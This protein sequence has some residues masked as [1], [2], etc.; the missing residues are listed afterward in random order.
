MRFVNNLIDVDLPH[1]TR[2]LRVV[3][4]WRLRRCDSFGDW[5]CEYLPV[6]RRISRNGVNTPGKGGKGCLGERFRKRERRAF[7]YFGKEKV[8]KQKIRKEENF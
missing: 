6:V 2:L 5:V 7:N 4:A 3:L 8:L 1:D